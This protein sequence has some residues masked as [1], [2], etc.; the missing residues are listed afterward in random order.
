[1]NDGN[2]LAEALLGLE[3]MMVLEVAETPDELIVKV[4][5]TATV[6]GCGRCGTRAESHDQDPVD[7]RDLACFGRPVRLRVSKRR[8]RCPEL[9]CETKTLTEQHAELPARHL[10]THR[11][12]FEA[13][14]QV[15]ELA[16]PVSQVADEYGV[17]WD[18]VVTA[19]KFHGEPLVDDPDRVG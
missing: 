15:G 10:L 2:G 17:C 14:R 6:V 7:I 9:D 5:T 1:M 3:A 11:A 8:W 19:V 18:T 16:R 4:E 13:A 12:G